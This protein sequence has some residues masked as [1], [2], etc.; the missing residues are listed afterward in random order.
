MGPLTAPLPPTSVAPGPAGAGADRARNT[1]AASTALLTDHYE[2]TMLDAA[3]EAGIAGNRAV[4]E[5][6]ARRLPDGRRYGVV[7]GTGRLLEAI[8]RFRFGG[9][10]LDHLAGQGFLRP[11]TL[12]WLDHFR[13][14]GSADG[15][16]E[17]E[18]YVATSPVLTVEA[19]FGE[20][21]LLETLILSVLNFDSAV[22][23]AA[24][25]MV[26][27]ARGTDLIEMG[28]RRTHEQAA[29]AAA[30]AAYIAG[31][32]ATSN[33]EAGRLYG[34]PTGGTASHAFTLA[35]ADER[36]AFAAQVA[37]LGPGTTL[38][39][40]TYDIPSGIRTA[41]DVAGS[42]L[43]A[44]RIDS[45]DLAV[46]ARRARQLLDQLGNRGTRIVVSGDLDEWAIDALEQDPGGRAPID[47]YGVGTR[48]VT[49][50]GA[51]TAE[52]IYKLVAVADGP[53]SE[54]PLRPVA[55]RSA[56]K[57]TVGG[58]KWAWRL[59]DGSGTAVGEHV[60]TGAHG[61][62]PLSRS[63]SVPMVRRGEVVHEPS[64]EDIR[65][66]HR[67]AMAE[68]PP[69]ALSSVPGPPAFAAAGDDGP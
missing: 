45:G 47:A 9:S 1:A 20:A 28:G 10:E 36:T 7:A 26:T 19:S 14:G 53:G 59:L 57:A 69:E 6:F 54:A 68:L 18:L 48:V 62:P 65:S 33:L 5:V 25:R 41:V 11:A 50:S 24:A 43:G 67:A 3:L 30:R 49:G 16:R 55:K 23:S 39:V 17:G 40:D 46:E 58:R 31:F 27:A 37:A 66:H 42:D 13:F 4:F 21:L 56:A 34:V 15:Y 2:L 61:G 44:V 29:P 22:A 63:L 32:A 51:P 8:A 12:E 35:N 38:L 52:M 60:G 64:M